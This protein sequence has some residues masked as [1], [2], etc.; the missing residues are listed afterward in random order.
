MRRQTTYESGFTLVEVLVSLFIFAL[1]SAGTMSAMFQTFAAKDRL[2]AASTELSDIA[3]FR[4]I[5]RADINAMDLRPMRDGVGGTEQF[6]VTTRDPAETA[7]LLT[8]TRLGRSNPAGA[9][10]GQSERVRYIFR[11][12]QFIR[13]TLLHENPAQRDDWSS[14]VLLENLEQ[15]E[16]VFRASTPFGNEAP[17]DI[18]V[19]EWRVP[20]TQTEATIRIEGALQFKLTDAR[21]F[22]TA[23][24]FELSL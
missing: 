22:E 23:H 16:V 10:R 5:L 2:D 20:L 3:A 4:A 6:L 1:I 19:E 21:G 8:F 9:A 15:V 13:E 14:R 11:D 17:I 7:A 12:G 24:L 18:V